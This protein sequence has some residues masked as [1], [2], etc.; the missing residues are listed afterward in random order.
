M[1]P[2]TIERRDDARRFAEEIKRDKQRKVV[3]LIIGAKG[4]TV[5]RSH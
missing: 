4:I 5:A 3:A 1:R 2:A